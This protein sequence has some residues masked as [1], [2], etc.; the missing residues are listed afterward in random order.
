MT[1]AEWIRR[2]RRKHGLPPLPLPNRACV[3]C[4][5]QYTPRMRTSVACS[6]ECSERNARLIIDAWKHHNDALVRARD[7]GYQKAARAR[8]K[9]ARNAAPQAL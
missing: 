1:K 5:E 6:P 9:A 4:N 7:C 3:V 8:R 2:W